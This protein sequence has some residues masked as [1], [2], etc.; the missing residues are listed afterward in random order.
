MK[1]DLVVKTVILNRKLKNILLV[2]RCDND[3]IDPGEWEQVGGNMKKGETPEEA[4]KREVYEETGI[5]NIN[6]V[7]QLYS[8]YVNRDEPY[9]ILVYLCETEV[10]EIILSDEHQDYKWVDK[11]ECLRILNGG[12]RRDYIK[13]KILDMEW[14]EKYDER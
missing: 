6:V 3:E 4:I 9:L 1:V 10:E 5:E 11:Q 14:E 13:H 2:R 12:I 8:T 7:S